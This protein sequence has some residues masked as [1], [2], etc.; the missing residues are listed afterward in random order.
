MAPSMNKPL[1]APL[2]DLLNTRTITDSFPADHGTC[3]PTI[4]TVVQTMEDGEILSLE[5][6]VLGWL[7]D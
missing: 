1:Y 3:V 4:A 5:I 7:T 6:A 2:Y